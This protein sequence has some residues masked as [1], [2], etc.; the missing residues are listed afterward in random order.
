MSNAK[1]P[2]LYIFESL[3]FRGKKKKVLLPIPAEEMLETM[4]SRMETI[5]A[6]VPADPYSVLMQWS[7][8]KPPSAKDMIECYSSLKRLLGLLHLGMT[9]DECVMRTAISTR[10][11]R[12]QYALLGSYLNLSKGVRLTIA[13]SEYPDIFDPST[14]GQLKAGEEMHNLAGTFQKLAQDLSENAKVKGEIIKQM[15]YPIGSFGAFYCILS[16]MMYFVL[17]RLI[18]V[19]KMTKV[20]VPFYTQCLLD[21]SVVVKAQP[22]VLLIPIAILIVMFVTKHKWWDKVMKIVPKLPLLGDHYLKAQIALTVGTM[23][24]LISNKVHV[25]N[26]VGLVAE[27]GKGLEMRKAFLAT[28]AMLEAG[29][30]TEKCFGPVYAYFGDVAMDFKTAVDIGSASKSLGESLTVVADNYR[31]N[32]MRVSEIV[33]KLMEPLMVVMY[34]SVMLGFALAIYVPIIEASTSNM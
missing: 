30:P 13:L 29:I 34:G 24:T 20:K 23:A 6:P 28:K 8:S 27:T 4:T 22:A 15:M 10:N 31:A 17:P 1:A 7:L 5:S 21:T 14:L 18:P 33:T 3:D 16:A 26:A 25:H 11:I 19:F 2:L 12:L 32:F 9:I